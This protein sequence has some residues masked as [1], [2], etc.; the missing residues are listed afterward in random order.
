MGVIKW[1]KIFYKNRYFLV[2][3]MGFCLIFWGIFSVFP[4]I[5]HGISKSTLENLC[6]FRSICNDFESFKKV[7]NDVLNLVENFEKGLEPYD[8]CWYPEVGETDTEYMFFPLIKSSDLDKFWDTHKNKSDFLEYISNYEYIDDSNLIITD[9]PIEESRGNCNYITVII[10]Y[11]INNYVYVTYGYNMFDD[12][13]T[14]SEYVTSR[15]GKESVY[16]PIIKCEYIKTT[17]NG[18]NHIYPQYTLISGNDV[19]IYNLDIST[20]IENFV[21]FFNVI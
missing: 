17:I 4:R 3:F 19:Y 7:E 20:G 15:T 6:D 16:I 5:R 10:S 12:L 8:F 18:I 11:W 21:D 13:N 9:K 1:H 2:L 14:I